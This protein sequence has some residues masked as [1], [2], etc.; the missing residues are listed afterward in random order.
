MELIVLFQGLE[1]NMSGEPS[2]SSADTL[3]L[4]SEVIK[5]FKIKKKYIINCYGCFGL[6]IWI[7]YNKI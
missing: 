3:S 6:T 5:C 7:R 2:V 1:D 4:S